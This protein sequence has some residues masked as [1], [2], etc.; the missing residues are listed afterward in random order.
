M[1]AVQAARE[2]LAHEAYVLALATQETGKRAVRR[3]ERLL[4]DSK[5]PRAKSLA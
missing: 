2:G 5:L 3:M 1:A 4:A